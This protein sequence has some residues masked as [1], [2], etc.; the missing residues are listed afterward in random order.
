MISAPT[1]VLRM[2]ALTL[3]AVA[4]VGVPPAL[5]TPVGRPTMPQPL[6][7]AS[8]AARILPA[9]KAYIGGESVPKRRALMRLTRISVLRAHRS[10]GEIITVSCLE[11]RGGGL[12]PMRRRGHEDFF[13]TRLLVSGKSR[14]VIYVRRSGW[15]GRFKEYTL[16]PRLRSHRLLKQGCLAGDVYT[17]ISCAVSTRF[18]Y[19]GPGTEFAPSCPTSPCLAVARVTGFQDAAGGLRN[20]SSVQAGGHVVAWQIA[21]GAPAPSQISFFD[22]N[23][24]GP[25]EAGLA[26]LAPQPS[27]SFT[28]KL[29]AQS[30]AAEAAALFRHRRAVRA[31]TAADGAGGRRDRAHRAHLGA[32]ACAGI[33]E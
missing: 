8:A 15:I 30:P 3:A 19:A 33:R 25:A 29:T 7:R 18:E 24:G 21:L 14:L 28:Y 16:Q 27:P 11:C 17:R 32:S 1:S 4:V 2:L 23:E 12:G 9:F 10:H 6:A 20:I 5:G 22:A 31:R 13:L 26:V